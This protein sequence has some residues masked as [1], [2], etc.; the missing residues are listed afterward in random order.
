M[1]GLAELSG[2]VA[3]FS[4]GRQLYRR[5]GGAGRLLGRRMMKQTALGGVQNLVGVGT[6]LAG[7]VSGGAAAA[8]KDDLSERADAASAGLQIAG[9]SIG[10][11]SGAKSLWGA[12]RRSKK[13]KEK[14]QSYSSDEMKNLAEF[15]SSSQGKG[16]KTLGILSNIGGIVGGGFR[17]A[18][19][20]TG[21]IGGAVSGGIGSLLGIGQSVYAGKKQKKAEAQAGGHIDYLVSQLSSRN[22][23]AVS[24]ANEVLKI[25]G[26]ADELKE[27]ADSDTDALR[28]LLMQKMVK[29]G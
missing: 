10:M 7:M 15:V 6:G 17:L 4:R 2:N 28:E 11:L 26:S 1:G 22:A 19:G 20:K 3:G 25:K 18:G 29:Y 12:F 8:G 21:L 23:E 24:F 16:S 13:A 14:A 5:G 27:M 9:E